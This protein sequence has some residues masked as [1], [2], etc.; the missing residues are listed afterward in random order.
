MVKEKELN[1]L[2]T[3]S[4]VLSENVN[5]NYYS[6]NGYKEE[7][8]CIEKGKDY[9][10]VF[11]AERNNRFDVASFDTVVE[12]CLCLIHRVCPKREEGLLLKNEF[13]DRIVSTRIA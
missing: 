11:S 3:I 13:L 10:Q 9:W 1:C 8:V 5:P 12:A 7:A 2:Q 6:L 4:D